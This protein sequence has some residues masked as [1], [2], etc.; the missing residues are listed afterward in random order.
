M[1]QGHIYQGA[2]HAVTYSLHIVHPALKMEHWKDTLQSPVI[3][4]LT[5]FKLID[6]FENICS[7]F[8]R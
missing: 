1:N 3:H 7:L 2:F 4:L 5:V 6:A 8:L